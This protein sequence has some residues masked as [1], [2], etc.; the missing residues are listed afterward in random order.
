[1]A[2]AEPRRKPRLRP[3]CSG[4][5]SAQDCRARGTGVTSPDSMR[6]VWMG[7]SAERRGAPRRRKDDVRAQVKP[8][9]RC[10]GS[11]PAAGFVEVTATSVASARESREKPVDSELRSRRVSGMPLADS[12]EPGHS[13]N[14]SRTERAASVA[15][16]VAAWSAA[17]AGV[18]WLAVAGTRPR[19]WRAGNLKNRRGNRQS[20]CQH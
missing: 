19:Q 20:W 3:D 1:M 18:P 8:G 15:L 17:P 10:A 9:R 16:E 6:P 12:D 13:E 2:G 4:K 7:A 11:A 14:H 5:R